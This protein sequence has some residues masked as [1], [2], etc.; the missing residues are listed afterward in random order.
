MKVPVDL[1]SDNQWLPLTSSKFKFRVFF[2]KIHV[3]AARYKAWLLMELT[4]KGKVFLFFSFCCVMFGCVKYHARCPALLHQHATDTQEQQKQPHS[5]LHRCQVRQ[6]K[7]C[8]CWT[9][10]LEEPPAWPSY[11]SCFPKAHVQMPMSQLHWTLPR[12]A[13]HLPFALCCRGEQYAELGALPIG[14]TGTADGHCLPAC[15][16]QCCLLVT[17]AKRH[18]G[19]YAGHGMLTVAQVWVLLHERN[20]QFACVAKWSRSSS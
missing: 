20:A 17:V 16:R 8:R 11:L 14:L 4:L 2:L 6:L 5:R 19:I 15:V 9:L 12:F 1:L 7:Q 13:A 18:L 3:W 10:P